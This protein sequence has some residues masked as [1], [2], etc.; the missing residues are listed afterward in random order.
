MVAPYQQDHQLPSAQDE[1]SPNKRAKAA[2]TQG[3]RCEASAYI[4]PPSRLSGSTE[5]EPVESECGDIQDILERMTTEEAIETAMLLVFPQGQQ[6]V[7]PSTSPRARARAATA[8]LTATFSA[9][10]LTSTALATPQP[11]ATTTAVAAVPVPATTLT[12]PTF[13]SAAFATTRIATATTATRTGLT[14][15]QRGKEGTEQG[16][17]CTGE[18]PAASQLRSGRHCPCARVGRTAAAMPSPPALAAAPR[19]PVRWNVA[20][21]LHSVPTPT[22][23]TA[24]PSRAPELLTKAAAHRTFVER[25]LSLSK[26]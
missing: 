8:Q 18:A 14:L 22:P 7:T 15:E 2:P 3:S 5:A 26:G 1:R 19:P 4:A 9:A 11:F 24:E 6:L 25:C 20:R 13:A 23:A 17:V 21:V 10:S 12:A 16:C